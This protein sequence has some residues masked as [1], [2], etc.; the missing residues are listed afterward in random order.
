MYLA[1]ASVSSS[2]ELSEQQSNLD[3]SE[4]SA[5]LSALV[6]HVHANPESLASQPLRYWGGWLDSEGYNASKLADWL[7][8]LTDS[9]QCEINAEQLQAFYNA[10]VLH[11]ISTEDYIATLT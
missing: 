6:I 11:G 7:L 10:G 8:Q 3:L 9:V 2:H 4:A 5:A 1:L